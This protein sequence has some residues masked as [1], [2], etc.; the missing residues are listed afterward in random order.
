[1]YRLQFIYDL[2]FSYYFYKE[3]DNIKQTYLNNRS[4]D[5]IVD[6]EIRLILTIN[7]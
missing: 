4:P 1:M 5:N 2:L 3:P 6:K 7:W